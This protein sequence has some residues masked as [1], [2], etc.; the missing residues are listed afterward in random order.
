MLGL[1]AALCLAACGE[2]KSVAETPD[3]TSA[4][5][6]E[7]GTSACLC[8]TSDACDPGLLCITGRC[9]ATQGSHEPEAPLGPPLRPPP[10]PPTP[11]G[12]PSSEDAGSDAGP[13]DSG[14]DEPDASADGGPPPT[15]AA[16]P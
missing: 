11:P 10:G 16:N 4:P 2:A 7:P 8:S 1:S 12:A 6:C 9:F 14:P 3:A 13:V 15:D 5:L